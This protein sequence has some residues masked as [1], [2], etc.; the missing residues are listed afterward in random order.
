MQINIARL[1][2][3]LLIMALTTVGVMRLLEPG[4]I[5]LPEK[6]IGVWSTKAPR[7]DG[8]FLQIGP[9]EITI[10][11]YDQ[12]DVYRV[13]RFDLSVDRWVRFYTAHCIGPNGFE[14]KITFWYD[15]NIE[16]LRLK[17]PGQVI[18]RKMTPPKKRL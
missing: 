8:R 2:I 3:V 13:K 1:T 11:V 14:D 12:R 7:Y 9:Q 16:G 5:T 15:E 6:F 4:P 17:N 10:G 18:W